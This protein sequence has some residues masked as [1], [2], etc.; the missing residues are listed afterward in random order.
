MVPTGSMSDYVHAPSFVPVQESVGASSL[1]LRNAVQA[2]AFVPSSSEPANTVSAKQDPAIDAN[3]DDTIGHEDT[4][5]RLDSTTTV[6]GA[7]AVQKKVRRPNIQMDRMHTFAPIP[8]EQAM[9]LEQAKRR[10]V[11]STPSTQLTTLE[12][13][14]QEAKEKIASREAAKIAGQNNSNTDTPPNAPVAPR[15]M[16]VQPGAEIPTTET[17]E[18]SAAGAQQQQEGNRREEQGLM[19]SMYASP[20]PVN[21]FPGPRGSRGKGRMNMK[22]RAKRNGE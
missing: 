6:L 18:G 12:Q 2:P 9:V 16:R 7:P 4:P 13:E 22:R 3:E 11:A 8:S 19:A 10:W 1:A 15:K 21:R 17:R 5:S 20:S 14:L